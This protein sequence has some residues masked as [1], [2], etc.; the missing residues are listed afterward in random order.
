MLTSLVF[1]KTLCVAFAEDGEHKCFIRSTKACDYLFC[2]S[3][4]SF[5]VSA[6]LMLSDTFFIFIRNEPKGDGVAVLEMIF[7]G[8]LK[9]LRTL[10]MYN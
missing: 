7:S 1:F 6:A 9:H 10:R 4:F 8:K 5:I 2:L 3:V